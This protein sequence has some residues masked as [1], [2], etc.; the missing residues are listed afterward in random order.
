MPNPRNPPAKPGNTSEWPHSHSGL[1]AS[2]DRVEPSQSDSW[3][4][5]NLNV[6]L[7]DAYLRLAAAIEQTVESI[8][9]S[10]TQGVLVYVNPAFERITGY[11]RREIIGQN[12]RIFKSGQHDDE[13]YK[14]MWE[15]VSRGN[16]WSGLVVNKKKDGSLHSEEMTISPIRDTSGNIVNYVAVKRDVTRELA[17]EEQLRQS[18]KMEAVGHLAGGIA[19]DFNNLLTVI[20]GN[21]ALLLED[22]SLDPF[23]SELVSDI[24]GAAERASGLTRQLLVVSRKQPMKLTRVDLN[25]VVESLSRMLERVLGEAVTLNCKYAPVLPLVDADRGMLQQVLLNLVL[26]ARDAMPTG[27]Q[28][29]IGTSEELPHASTGSCGSNA[30]SSNYVCLRVSDTGCGIMPENLSKIFDP[31]FTTKEVGKGTGLGLA[32]VYSIVKQ[33]QGWVELNSEVNRGSTFRVYMPAS[34]SASLVPKADTGMDNL[35]GGTETILVAED[36]P[37]VRRTLCKLLQRCGYTVLKAESGVAALSLWENHKNRI[38]LLLT[39]VMMP[40]GILGTELALRLRTE[41]PQLKVIFTSG[42]DSEV[43]GKESK[44][45]QGMRM[46]HKPWL[47]REVAETVRDCLD[48]D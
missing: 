7:E 16:V 40:G 45:G 34:K 22:P 38:Q 25:E 20:Q 48:R 12:V 28:L 30:T 41:K 29:E 13:F 4:L 31:F 46:I 8:M 27:G 43:A 32:T 14:K 24:S 26:N 42:Y 23:C 44:P 33:H 21:A 5:A 15:A 36:D 19:H 47:P 6:P 39:D 1:K 18:Q 10:D 37:A 11:S 17:L 9:I 2:V 3:Q 35:P